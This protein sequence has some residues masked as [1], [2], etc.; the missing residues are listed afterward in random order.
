MPSICAKSRIYAPLAA[1]GGALQ[2]A[3]Q[4]TETEV[5]NIIASVVAWERSRPWPSSGP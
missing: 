2:V 5:L 3:A 4:Q 1:L